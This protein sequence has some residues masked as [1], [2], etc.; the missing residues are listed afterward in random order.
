MALTYKKASPV[1]A[2]ELASVAGVSKQLAIYLLGDNSLPPE[3]PTNELTK[4][5]VSLARVADGTEAAAY[6]ILKIADDFISK[7]RSKHVLAEEEV[8]ASSEV[9]T[10]PIRGMNL[11][12]QISGVM[13]AVSTALAT[14]RRQAGEAASA[15]EDEASEQIV[16]ASARSGTNELSSHANSIRS[17]ATELNEELQSSRNPQSDRGDNLARS[18]TDLDILASLVE[19]AL[20]SKDAAVSWVK[21][22][23]RFFA[24]YPALLR[25]LGSALVIGADI[26]KPAWDRWHAVWHRIGLV[27]IEE[28]KGLGL[29]LGKLVEAWENEWVARKV[30]DSKAQDPG[31]TVRPPE[32]PQPA[33][34]DHDT[35][36]A[37]LIE[38]AKRTKNNSRLR[39][40][41]LADLVFSYR[42]H[43]E[44]FR[45]LANRAVNDQ[46]QGIRRFC[47]AEMGK[48]EF[49]DKN[50]VR[51]HS[52]LVDVFRSEHVP[53][54]RTAIMK[55]VAKNISPRRDNSGVSPFLREVV[56][57][58]KCSPPQKSLAIKSLRAYFQYEPETLST[59]LLAT[60][61]KEGE[62]R[63]RALATIS[64]EFGADDLTRD[65]VFALA[66]G[67]Q[68]DG[69]KHAA[70]NA[71]ER[72]LHIWKGCYALLAN[73]EKHT[74]DSSVLKHISRLQSMSARRR[75]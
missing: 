59:I 36:R 47:V 19:M 73:L 61:D 68:D 15:S 58:P 17:Q 46:S 29:D 4:V 48:I 10:P 37:V 63:A 35:R 7:V 34:N 22:L 20:S 11:D 49:N 44:T 1:L 74:N 54:I 28:V 69:V 18:L 9:L 41:A 62:V 38:M 51:L 30:S 53:D 8:T 75:K 3:F 23:G 60:R 70:L 71:V 25:K 14:C 56:A 24:N 12:Q 72:Q 39:Q 40:G 27:V 5:C 6:E 57:S 2:R 26:A 32:E 31:E 50:Y 42:D 65:I 13:V 55:V 33:A 21:S 16:D 45:L 64:D 67:D 52:S 43:E 66:N